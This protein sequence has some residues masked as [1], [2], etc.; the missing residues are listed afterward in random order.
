MKLLIACDMEGI[1]GVVNWDQVNPSHPEY[2]R[3]RKIMTA[4]VNAAI[5]GAAAGGA[6]E[7]LVRDGHELSNNLLLEELDPRAVLIA[8]STT[9]LAMVQGVESGVDA[10]IFIGYHARA[11]SQNAILDH[12]WSSARVANVWLNSRLVGEFGLNSAVCGHFDVPVLMVSG[13][14]TLCAEAKEWAPG[15]ETAAVKRAVGRF[16]AECLPVAVSH[17]LIR[18]AAEKAVRQFLAGKGPAPLK[19]KPP[20]VIEVE[21]IA[22]Q[23]ADTA[24]LLPGARRLD[25][26]RLAYEAEDMIQA[27][28]AFRSMVT[29]APAK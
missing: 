27:Y 29:L 23:M 19:I 1:S 20:V 22:S 18:D 4:E 17:Q 24:G 11:G 28:A 10:V 8:G 2:S 3:F 12:T 7:F 16:A 25:G 5:Q 9:P 6:T 21:M 13:D 15:V 14:Q 26:R